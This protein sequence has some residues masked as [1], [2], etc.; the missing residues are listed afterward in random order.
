MLD[1]GKTT[2]DAGRTTSDVVI[3]GKTTIDTGRMTIDVGK[4][5]IDI[6][7]TTSDVVIVG[8]TPIDAGG[9]TM[10]D[11]CKTTID[12]G[13][14][15]IDIASTKTDRQNDNRERWSIPGKG[16]WILRRASTTLDTIW[17][18][19]GG[20]VDGPGDLYSSR[21]RSGTI[22]GFVLMKYPAASGIYYYPYTY[23]N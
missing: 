7:R 13:R 16:R 18:S 3:V 6:G 5:T 4:R 15:T 1:V 23:L 17:R 22:C 12:A 19:V 14:T 20:P 11:V 21:K 2:T 10:L 8:K 9:R